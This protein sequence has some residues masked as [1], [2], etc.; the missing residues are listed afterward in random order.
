MK[1]N[2][3]LFVSAFVLFA[4][5]ITTIF[6]APHFLPTS[7][8][9]AKQVSAAGREDAYRANNLG[10]AR[11]E[12]FDYKAGAESFRLA[13]TLDPK[14]KI[15]QIN[16]AIALFNV[17]DIENAL[18]A[19]RTAAEIAPE[20]P[21]PHYILGLI[22]KNQNRAEDAAASFKRV[23]EIDPNDV[24]ANVNLGQ[25][26]VS[27]RKYAEAVSVFRL[28]LDAEPYNA[29]A[30]YTLATALLR[31]DARAEGQQLMTRFQALRQSGAATSI[32]QNYLEQGRYAE[33]IVS[34]GAEGD[35]VDRRTP[36]INFVDAT[37]EMFG[38]SKSPASK[39][40]KPKIVRN[41]VKSIEKN[42]LTNKSNT[43]TLFDYDGDGKLDLVTSSGGKLTLYKNENGRFRDVTAESGDLAKDY[44][45]N[46][47]CL[48]A[49]D[50]DND[51]KTDLLA[52]R[53]DGFTLYRNDGNGRFTDVT[54]AANLPVRKPNDRALISSQSCAFVDADHDGDLDVFAPGGVDSGINAGASEAALL[55]NRL[56]RNNGDGTFTDIGEKAK[57]ADKLEA[58]AVVPTDY[59]N[60]RDTDLLVVGEKRTALY[61]NR[62]D[63]SFKDVAAEV[64]LDIGGKSAAAGDVNKDGFTDFFI[65]RGDGESRLFLSDG[66][67]KFK[68][69]KIS[70]G[71]IFADGAQFLDYDN[72]G[73]LDLVVSGSNG[74]RVW[75][76]L[77]DEWREINLPNKLDIGGGGIVSGDLDGDGDLDFVF[78]PPTAPVKI[79]RNDGGNANR[80][81]TLSLQGR[82]SNRTGTGAKIDMRSGSLAQKL[83]SYSAS[84][85]PA[86]S[87]IHF[88]LGRR[89]KPDAVR[90]IWTSGTVQA[91]LEFPEKAKTATAKNFA[92]L[93]IEELDRK[94]SSCP[95]LYVWNGE[96]FE[97]IT[98]FLGG[99]EM[100]NWKEAGAYHY[101]DS[102]EFVRITSDQLKPK[103]GRYEI[104]VTNELEEVL[105]LDHLKLVA[106][107]HDANAEVYPNEGLGI[108]TAGKRI[109][110]TTRNARAPIS[111]ADT[112]GKSVLAKIENLDRRFY[113]N[114]KSRNIRGYAE[115][116]NLTLNLD[117]KKGYDGRTLLLLTGWTD[118]AFSSDNLAASQS[119]KSLFLPKLQVRDKKGEWQ[120]VI[121]SI[122]ISV[123]RPQT[124]VVDLTG[125]FLSDSR[126]V[127]IVTNFKT[128]WDKIEVDT[129]EQQDVKTIETQ[130]V[131]ASL[132]ERGFS[133][134]IKYGEMIAANYDT[135]LND[136]RWK[137]FSGNFTRLGVVS[138]LLEAVDDVFVISKTGDELVLSFEALPELPKNKKYTFLLFADG[139]SKEMDINSGSPDAVFPLPFKRMTKYPYAANEQFPMTEEKRRIYDEYTTRPV[140]GVL[141][142]IEFG[143]K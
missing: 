105:F 120:T 90:V 52:A 36:R 124:L 80:S 72:D 4:V 6:V 39:N 10:V 56:F 64:G 87:E 45:Y 24:G 138:A 60:R 50:Y 29:T 84:P 47:G 53:A 121:E 136:G 123:G 31:T 86:P 32:G 139:Y 137:Y 51:L 132:R 101:P 92:P 127:R 113:D 98:D 129:S 117:D 125:K 93:K 19:A 41:N 71:K 143:I 8:Q 135:V 16:L 107:E 79:L 11:L 100:G 12:Q 116:H 108:P 103:N 118:Y 94:P 15:A 62:R 78:V 114:F 22:A 77:G 43:A 34:N 25:I 66:K 130:P 82:A 131:Q 111:A 40:A 133:E 27:Q 42:G 89:E 134:E 20:Q 57:I 63:G 70:T 75:R 81:I 95:Y 102:D 96:K 112:N 14:L 59:D 7:A 48:V 104:R 38:N 28:A 35:L 128:F 2:L 85:A 99:G 119:G 30:M 26:Y 83:E 37:N 13:L 5:S 33:A 109:L 55:P 97:F 141:P 21:Q 91:E 142:R 74:F 69:E 58:N 61:R 44:E 46:S 126:E 88:G 17:Q 122:G 49:G 3:R 67:G 115:T 1:V 54:E 73:L 140:R 110:Y 18:S 106:V 68:K 23:L 76:N 9:S 65:G